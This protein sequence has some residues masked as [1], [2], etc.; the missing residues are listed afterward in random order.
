[1]KPSVE[2]M[3]RRMSTELSVPARIGHTALLLVALLGSVAIGSLWLTEPSLPVRTQ[4]AFAVLVAIN[5]S[6]VAFAA[7]VLTRRRVLLA[8]HSIIAARM[9]VTF[10][11]VFTAGALVVGGRAGYAA[12]G[13]GVVLLAIAIAMLR[14]ARRRFEELMERRRALEVS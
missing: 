13:T 2:E 10:C 14:S 7:W 5:L 4:V 8:G 12:G 6:W 11:A 9:A 3:Q 1:M